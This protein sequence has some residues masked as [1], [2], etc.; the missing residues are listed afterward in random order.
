MARIKNMLD[1]IENIVKIVIGL[2]LAIML[3]VALTEVFRR[4]FLG[5]S[6]SWSE[7]LVRYLIIW[8]SFLG[9]A[10]AFK[11]QSLVYFDMIVCRIFKKKKLILSL[12]TNTITLI[13]IGVIFRNAI[14]TILKPSILN[15]NSV[16]LGVP[17]IVPFLSVPVGLGLMFIFGLYHYKTLFD[18]YKQGLFEKKGGHE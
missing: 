11:D 2:L 9:A 6:F 17:M 18:S 3:L 5:R 7:E 14:Q 4:Y 16:G 10:V 8:I 1:T 12:I 15:Q 13:F